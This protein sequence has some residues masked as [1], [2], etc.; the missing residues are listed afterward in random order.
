MS[1][2]HFSG[3]INELTK[4]PICDLTDVNIQ[5]NC[6]HLY[7]MTCIREWYDRST[8]CPMCRQYITHVYN[9]LN[10]Q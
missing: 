2:S 4:C 7:C 10:K 6:R 8:K 9:V 1:Q 5:T 3:C